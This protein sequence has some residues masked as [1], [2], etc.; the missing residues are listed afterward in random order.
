MQTFP[1]FA[2]AFLLSPCSNRPPPVCLNPLMTVQIAR[3]QSKPNEQRLREKCKSIQLKKNKSNVQQA[4]TTS[5]A[6]TIAG[7]HSRQV[8]NT[9]S[10]Y[11]MRSTIWRKTSTIVLKKKEKKTKQNTLHKDPEQ[12]QRQQQ[13]QQRQLQHMPQ[14]CCSYKNFNQAFNTKR[15]T[16]RRRQK[17]KATFAAAQTHKQFS[18]CCSCCLCR[19]CCCCCCYVCLAA[20]YWHCVVAVPPTVFAV[21]H[22]LT[23]RLSRPK[24]NINFPTHIRKKRFSFSTAFI[25]YFLI[26]NV[27]G[28]SKCP[29]T[30]SFPSNA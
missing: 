8:R 12:Q 4:A 2:S 30:S 22:K 1:A 18:N 3:Q 6:A 28:I 23:C 9:R 17:T 7:T 27:E 5:S 10:G 13:K 29:T 26:K 21:V 16:S 11:Y 25:R 15:A 20:F 14:K 24:S 19:C